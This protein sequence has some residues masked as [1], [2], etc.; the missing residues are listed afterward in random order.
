M[1]I[2][3]TLIKLARAGEDRFD[4]S[5][6]QIEIESPSRLCRELRFYMAELANRRI[7]KRSDDAPQ[8]KTIS[9]LAQQIT[10]PK[11]EFTSGATLM[12]EIEL[13]KDQGNWSVRHC[14]FDLRLFGRKVEMASVH[15]RPEA[16]HEPH[17]VP[18]C[19]LHVRPSHVHIPF[20]ATDPRLILYLMCEHV[21]PDLGT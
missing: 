14:Q 7:L 4:A 16:T 18:R 2:E 10:C 20:P 15:L 12:F 11:A 6:A 21:E 5:L 1:I 8:L 17:R 13:Q 9:D 19:H 3:D